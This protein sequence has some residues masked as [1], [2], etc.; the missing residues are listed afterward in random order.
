MRTT[1]RLDE[2]LMKEAK[3]AAAESGRTFTSVIEDAL[4]ESLS[5]R[6]GHRARGRVRLPTF[7]G[8]GLLPGVDL[9]D[10]SVLLDRMEAPR[11]PR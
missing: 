9:D 4:R 3:K 6:R 8:R 2:A 11:D 1:V 10:T 7:A 5:R